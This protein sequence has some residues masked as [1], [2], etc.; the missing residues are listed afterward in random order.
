MP[1]HD[2][3]DPV[4]TKERQFITGVKVNED[5][6]GLDLIDKEGQEVH[7]PRE[8]IKKY[9]TQKISMMPGNFMDLLTVQEVADTLA[10]LQTLTLPAISMNRP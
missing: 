7:I 5:D 1:V 6:S 8:R 3:A 9:K 2:F 10:Y 4:Y